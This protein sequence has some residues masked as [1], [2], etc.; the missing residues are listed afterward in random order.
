MKI[1]NGL[2]VP[3]KKTMP[4]LVIV[5]ISIVTLQS[6]CSPPPASV[7][8]EN[9]CVTLQYFPRRLLDFFV[10]RTRPYYCDDCLNSWLIEP[11]G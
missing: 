6:F 5:D 10:T 9:A 2:S 3:K 7:L 8:S 1:Q 4:P 11:N